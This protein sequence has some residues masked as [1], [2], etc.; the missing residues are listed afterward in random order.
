[1]FWAQRVGEQGLNIFLRLPSGW[2]GDSPRKAIPLD[3]GN[4][5]IKRH[6]LP[7]WSLKSLKLRQINS[8]A[9]QDASLTLWTFYPFQVTKS[10]Q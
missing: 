7:I 2:T 3:Y 1:M 9:G 4:V 8:C 6:H 5:T 10:N